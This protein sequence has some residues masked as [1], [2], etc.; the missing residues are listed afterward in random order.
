MPGL[1]TSRFSYPRRQQ[2]RRLGRAAAIAAAGLAATVGAVAA[3]LAGLAA[4]AVGLL[5]VAAALAVRARHW[6]RLAVRSGV[7]ARS[8]SE[9]Q[10]ALSILQ[11]EGWRLRRSLRWRGRGDID[12]VAIAPTGIAF[13]IEAKTSR[14]EPRHLHTVRAFRPPGS[15]A[16]A[17]A[18]APAAR[19]GPLRHPRPAPP[20][21]R[22]RRAR[23][24]PRPDAA[25]AARRRPHHP[26]PR[27]PG[28][29]G[30]HGLAI[31]EPVAANRPFSRRQ[32]RRRCGAARAAP[33]GQRRATRRSA[34]GRRRAP[35]PA[36]PRVLALGRHRRDERLADRAPMNAMTP[37]P[38]RDSTT[39]PGAV[40][41]DLL[42][43]LDSRSRSLRR[44]PPTLARS[45]EGPAA[46]GRSG[47]TERPQR[48]QTSAP[49]APREPARPP[50]V[51]SAPGG[52]IGPHASPV[53]GAESRPSDPRGAT[54]CQ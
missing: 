27:L 49:G 23:R 6:R 7:G 8:E 54:D 36:V 46:P 14:Y 51:Q 38:A 40:A 21:Q 44:P 9:V 41:A 25:R 47:P 26:T 33:R 1:M 32:I 20:A 24:L 2:L 43:R 17:D 19:P 28:T 13:A 5:L 39:P 22:A 3:A 16:A 37:R 31:A 53:R 11:R 18:G 42:E 12:H 4:I 50:D 48:G 52:T 30:P 45:A 10:R 35:A 15:G 34:P 29:R